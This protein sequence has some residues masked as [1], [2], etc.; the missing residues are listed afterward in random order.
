MN[1][2]ITD[3]PRHVVQGRPVR[4]LLAGPGSVRPRVAGWAVTILAVAGAA[5]LVWSGIIHLMLWNDGYRDISVIGPL[6]LAQ[7]IGAIVIAGAIVVLRRLLVLA[8]GAVTLAATAI[9]LLLSVHVSLFGYRETL[10]ISYAGLSLTVEFTGAAILAV[11][12][13]IL[14]VRGRANP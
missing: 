6:F 13:A 9:G 4:L 10:A 12:A 14:A 8:A 5:L 11:A 7:G 2:K 3:P 1:V